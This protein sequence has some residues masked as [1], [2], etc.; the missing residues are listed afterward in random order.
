MTKSVYG[1]MRQRG[2]ESV[3]WGRKMSIRKGHRRGVTWV[4]LLV[5]VEQKDTTKSKRGRR[6][7]LLLAEN[8]E[9]SRNLSQSNVFPT[10]KL[11]S[12]KLKVRA[13]S[14]ICLGGVCIF[15]KEF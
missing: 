10:A 11:G 8:K 2:K 15:M 7:D 13:Y 5:G 9:N 12:F 4:L 1:T 3:C 14:R 6:K